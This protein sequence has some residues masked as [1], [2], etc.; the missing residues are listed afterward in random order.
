MAPSSASCQRSCTNPERACSSVPFVDASLVALGWAAHTGLRQRRLGETLTSSGATEQRDAADETRGPQWTRFAADLGVRRALG[1][2]RETSIMPFVALLVLAGVASSAPPDCTPAHE[3]DQRM[4]NL[5]LEIRPGMTL[6]ALRKL[7]GDPSHGRFYPKD[8]GT[9]EANFEPRVGE[10]SRQ[11]GAGMSCVIGPDDVVRSCQVDVG[12]F[13]TQFVDRDALA[14]LQ[15]GQA[16]GD[17]FHALCTPG[18]IDL[19]PSGDLQ[20]LYFATGGTYGSQAVKLTF[21][22]TGRLAK[23]EFG[24]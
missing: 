20:S 15:V 21:G 12:P 19:L 8:D 9:R 18:R 14:R 7:L 2:E 6:V 11:V 5:L 17:V 23:I 16:I 13:H 3:L 24:H 22:R 1:A 4:A 10:G